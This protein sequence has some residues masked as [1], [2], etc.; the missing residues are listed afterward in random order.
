VAA[1]QSVVVPNADWRAKEL[2]SALLPNRTQ[3]ESRL[4]AS[5]RMIFMPERVEQGQLW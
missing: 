3:P 5:Q 2:Q 1:Q 4:L